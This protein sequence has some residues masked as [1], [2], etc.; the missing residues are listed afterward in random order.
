MCF[1]Y[2]R[3]S[4]KCDTLERQ[5]LSGLQAASGQQFTSKSFYSTVILIWF[6]QQLDDLAQARILNARKI[7]E[8][9]G[10]TQEVQLEI[11]TLLLGPLDAL[12]HEDWGTF[13]KVRIAMEKRLRDPND[14]FIHAEQRRKELAKQ[15]RKSRRK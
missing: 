15:G 5:W 7:R 4:T 3:F 11:N 9:S 1:Y 14:V 8:M 6:L 10:L 12:E 13:G 2:S